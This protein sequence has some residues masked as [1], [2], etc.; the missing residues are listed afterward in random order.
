[1]L[2]RRRRRTRDTARHDR[3]QCR[4]RGASVVEAA[5]IT[6]LF[7]LLVFG[8]IEVGSYLFD[9]TSV[10]AAARDGAREGSASASDATA[11]R[12]V[13]VIARRGLGGVKNHIDGIIVFKATSSSSVVPPSCVAALASG[14]R[15]VADLCNIYR[16]A[17]LVNPDILNFG[18]AAQD[19]AAGTK[20]DRCWPAT[21]RNDVLTR[22]SSPD[23]L[24]VYIRADHRSISGIIPV[25]TV[26]ASI[27]VPLEAQR[28]SDE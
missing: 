14:L 22:T 17:D 12:N 25:R 16:K 6:P 11:D 2:L 10:R 20:W 24:G 15:G 13:L 3:A 1:M 26:T 28:A 18:T 4:E 19:C 5:L 21:E 23:F 8:I 7:L 27:I 9:L